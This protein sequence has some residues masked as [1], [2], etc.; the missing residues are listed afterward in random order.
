VLNLISSIYPNIRFEI[1]SIQSSGNSV[2]IANADNGGNDTTTPAV[3]DYSQLVGADFVANEESGNKTIRFNNPNTILFSFT[4]RVKAHVLKGTILA[5]STTS[6]STTS[7]GSTS[8]TT[9]TGNG[10]TSSSGTLLSNNSTLIKFT[11]NP[12]TGIVTTQVIQ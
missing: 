3:F 1:V 5:S 11:V 12:L 8:G 10:T 9:S 7:G 6:Q 4:A 2:T